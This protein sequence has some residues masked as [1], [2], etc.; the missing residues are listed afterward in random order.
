M[1]RIIDFISGSSSEFWPTKM[2]FYF[3]DND[4]ELFGK[5]AKPNATFD[6]KSTTDNGSYSYTFLPQIAQYVRVEIIECR[7]E[8]FNKGDKVAAIIADI[9]VNGLEILANTA[10]EGVAATV[11][12]PETGIR[13]DLV[14]L[15]ENDVYT[16]LQG[17]LVKEREA[18]KE[19]IK[20]LEDNGN[21]MASKVYDIFLLDVN[22]DILDDVGGREIKIYLP[23]S[24]YKGANT[25][26]AFVINN[27]WGEFNM[28]EF[29][30]EDD[31]FVTISSDPLTNTYAFCEFADASLDE[32]V[33]DE[34]PTDMDNTVDDDDDDDTFIEEDED[35]GEDEDDDKPKRKKKVKVV[36]KNNGGDINYLWIIIAAVAAVVVIAGGITLFLI[37]KKK[38]DNEA[39][40]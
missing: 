27:A 39:E 3:G 31:Y 4:M 22:G 18:T 29:N 32:E 38:K 23:K 6:G 24:L 16:T 5:D 21:V 7:N 36:R 13:V 8:F 28:V 19:E 37:L 2:N 14:A 33:D 1:V 12:D 20:S 35:E 15:R 30:T 9:R 34:T 10:S 11:T 40:E 25:E 26:D 17:I